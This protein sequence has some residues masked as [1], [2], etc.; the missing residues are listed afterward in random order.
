[1]MY[2]SGKLDGIM[3]KD[4][5]K[6]TKYSEW[7]SKRLHS[8]YTFE[9]DNDLVGGVAS[10]HPVLRVHLHAVVLTSLQACIS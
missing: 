7:S 10:A 5:F 2:E 1:M 9:G 8:H 3:E 6:K 4:F